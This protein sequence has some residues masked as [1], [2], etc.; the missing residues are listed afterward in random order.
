MYLRF[1]VTVKVLWGG[2]EGDA[3]LA[4]WSRPATTGLSL[5]SNASVLRRYHL[6]TTLTLFLWSTPAWEGFQRWRLINETWL[7]SCELTDPL[8]P[9]QEEEG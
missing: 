3:V 1:T 5:I 2:G 9:P 8:Q 4:N 6:T 7:G